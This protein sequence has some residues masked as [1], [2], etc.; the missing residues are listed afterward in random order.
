MPYVN[1]EKR[2]EVASASTRAWYQRN[3]GDALEKDAA[4]Y[5]ANRGAINTRTSHHRKGNPERQAYERRHRAELKARCVAFYGPGGIAVCWCCSSGED[6]VVDH[7]DGNGP[8]HRL[9]L[10]GEQ[11]AGLRFYLWLIK[12]GFPG[13]YQTLCRPCNSSKRN[14]DRCRLEH[15]GDG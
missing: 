2:R 12:E 8:S 10:F 7:V 1:P 3:R 14:G 6:L 5:Q 4:Y 11:R 13:G 15:E 9:E